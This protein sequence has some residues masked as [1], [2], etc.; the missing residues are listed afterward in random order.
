MSPSQ[1][2]A[3]VFDSVARL[4]TTQ[5]RNMHASMNSC[6]SMNGAVMHDNSS[7]VHVNS[8][9]ARGTGIHVI[10]MQLEF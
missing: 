7:G 6:G 2:V 5:T 3:H 10:Y 4:L 9:G 8:C 1:R